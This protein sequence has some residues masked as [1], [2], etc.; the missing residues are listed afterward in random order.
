MSEI[1]MI[2]G[3]PQLGF[4]TWKRKGDEGYQALIAAL[5][6]GYRHVDTAQIYENEAEVGQALGDFGLPREEMFITTKVW[7][8]HYGAGKMMPS[9]HE[10]LEKLKVD[11][12]D[13]L[14]LHWPSKHGEV[15]LE[16]YVSQLAEVYD[17]GL[18]KRIGVS[19]FTKALIAETETL[20]GDRKIA[21]NQVECHVFMN[22]RPI[23]DFCAERNIPITAY[24]P[25]AQ[26]RVKDDPVLNEI[27]KA[28]GVSAGAVALAYLL[29]LGI[30]A[31]PTSSNR[32]RAAEN[33]AAADISLSAAEMERLK[34][35]D[36][37]ARIV[38]PEWGPTFD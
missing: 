7:P 28:H 15:P 34:G 32:S 35:L 27:A 5:E 31:I 33:L 11:H 38:S 1:A 29:H 25:L 4:G 30:I 22:N 18:A 26:G 19:N 3:I 6:A 23:A 8:D 36:S 17:A 14:L 2:N 24:S 20:L 21:T 16:T 37:G 12:V 13:L 9:V 10:S